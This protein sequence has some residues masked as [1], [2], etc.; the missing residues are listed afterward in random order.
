MQHKCVAAAIRREDRLLLCQRSD[1]RKWFP[2]AW[3][4][5]GGHIQMGEPPAIA[6][7]REVKEELGIVITA[8]DR[9]PD[10]RIA[11]VDLTLAVWVIDQWEGELRNAEPEEH[12]ALAWFTRHDLAQLALAHADYLSL[13]ERVVFA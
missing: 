10:G 7:V 6:L 9:S 13:F 11:D 4:L 12:D 2:G 3:D 8:P 5:P 1:Q